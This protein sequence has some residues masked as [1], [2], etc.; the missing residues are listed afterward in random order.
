[1]TRLRLIVE[2]AQGIIAARRGIGVAIFQMPVPTKVRASKPWMIHR[3]IRMGRPGDSA[4]GF[5][6]VTSVNLCTTDDAEKVT[7]MRER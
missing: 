5:D 3:A 1:M 4:R 2:P 6:M 7:W